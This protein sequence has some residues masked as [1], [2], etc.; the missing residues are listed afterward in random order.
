MALKQ[1]FSMPFLLF[2]VYLQSKPYINHMNIES[3][4]DYCL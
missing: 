1:S 3:I 4:R 2:Y